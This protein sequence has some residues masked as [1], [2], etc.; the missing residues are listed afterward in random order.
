MILK[1]KDSTDAHLQQLDA[2]LQ[3]SLSDSERQRI[4]K[5]RAIFKAGADGEKEAAYH[6]DFH[7]R[8]S[9]NWAVIHDL[10]IECNGRVA[11]IDHLLINRFMQMYV[12]ESKNFRTKVRLANGGWERLNWKHWEGIPSPVEQNERH[13]TVLKDVISTHKLS[14]FRLGLPIP[15]DFVNAVLVNPS[16][17][18]TGDFPSHVSIYKMDTFVRTI[19]NEDPTPLGAMASLLKVVSSKTIEEFAGK[20]VAH[21][22]PAPPKTVLKETT[23]TYNV[24]PKAVPPTSAVCSSCCGPVSNAEAYFCRINK[25]RFGGA[26]LCKKCQSF[27]PNVEPKNK[28]ATEPVCADCAAAVDQKVVAFCRFNSKRFGGRMLCR[29]CQSNVR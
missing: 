13:I 11:Q 18:I 7:L 3:G 12:V 8:D 22:K 4:E 6:I 21:H 9:Q 14:P 28:V 26:I 27:A 17:S 1:S 25:T 24:A 20:L 23:A 10:R 2:A 5:E 29:E 19:T 16:C 15:V